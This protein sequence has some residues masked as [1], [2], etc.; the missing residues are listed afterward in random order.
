MPW[1]STI[2]ELTAEARNRSNTTSDQGVSDAEILGYLNRE[3]AKWQQIVIASGTQDYLFTSRTF[4]TVAGTH[5]Y[6]ID[7]DTFP[8]SRVPVYFFKILGVSVLING[9]TLTL[10]PFMYSERDR[11]SQGILGWSD[12]VPAYR[13]IGA[14]MQFIPTPGAVYPVSIYGI[15]IPTRMDGTITTVNGVAS[16]DE[17]AVIGAAFKIATKKG[18][19]DLATLLKGEQTELRG[20]IESL[21][22]SRDVGMPERVADVVG[23]P[24]D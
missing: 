23:W 18:L 14:D 20:I 12:A 5:T 15:P 3:I 8:L 22:A 6:A 10:R 17:Y 21:A 7:G 16:W 11:F 1:V 19:N 2:A 24:E 9:Q 13:M 4:N